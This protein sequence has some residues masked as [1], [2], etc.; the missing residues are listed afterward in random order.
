MVKP[1]EF[2]GTRTV[3]ML[4]KPEGLYINLPSILTSNW[5]SQRGKN[6]Q[7]FTNYLYEEQEIT[8]NV[9]ELK[10]VRLHS[11]ANDIKGEKSQDGKVTIRI[12]AL[13]AVMLSYSR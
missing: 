9:S 5:Q 11:N 4:T 2:E 12:P 7:F 10:D 3:P 8:I 6:A 1:L 13:S